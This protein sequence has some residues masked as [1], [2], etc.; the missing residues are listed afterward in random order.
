[1]PCRFTLFWKL[2][3]R[4]DHIFDI[5]Q[6]FLKRKINIQAF[7]QFSSENI[8]KRFGAF[9][10]SVHIEIVNDSLLVLLG[11][12]VKWIVVEMTLANGH[13]AYCL[14]LVIYKFPMRY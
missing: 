14:I 11:G 9:L 8:V 13:N 3:R 4:A 7:L 5:W 10:V 6:T 1:M 12:F 2:D